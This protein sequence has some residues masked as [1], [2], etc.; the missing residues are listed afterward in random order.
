VR[1]FVKRRVR[2]SPCIYLAIDRTR[3]YVYM[4]QYV[5]MVCIY[6]FIHICRASLCG[7]EAVQPRRP[8]K[9]LIHTHRIC[10]YI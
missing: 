5:Y 8:W 1:V 9:E 6:T 10:I 3:L 2:G 4:Y 7:T